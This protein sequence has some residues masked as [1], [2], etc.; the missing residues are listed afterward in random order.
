MYVWCFYISHAI[1]YVLCTTIASLEGA[2]DPEDIFLNGG[3]ETDALS[4]LNIRHNSCKPQVSA[5]ANPASAVSTSFREG[6]TV[7]LHSLS[8][9]NLNGKIGRCGRFK[10]GRYAVLLDN[11]KRKV[12]VPSSDYLFNEQFT[13]KKIKYIEVLFNIVQN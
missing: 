1:N 8:A 3:R 9:T 6:M 13:N 5:L 12:A 2:Y 4:L 7:Q 11:G 10:K